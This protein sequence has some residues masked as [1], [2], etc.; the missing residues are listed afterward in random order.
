MNG[1]QI[2]IL[3][4]ELGVDPEGRGY[5]GMSDA[6]AAADLNTAYMERN[7]DSVAGWQIYETIAESEFQLLDA[8]DQQTIRELYTLGDTI[9]VQAGRVKTNILA[10]FGAGTTTRDNLIALAKETVTRAAF[11]ELPEVK[12][13][14]VATARGL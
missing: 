8:P 14:N 10:K 12:T 11:L 1:A 9:P 13:G 7:I 4:D 6:Q 2:D 5:S 3:A